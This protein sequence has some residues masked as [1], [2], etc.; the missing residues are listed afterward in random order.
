MTPYMV[1]IRICLIINDRVIV[2]RRTRD[3]DRCRSRVPRNA[4]AQ[5]RT[6]PTIDDV[7]LFRV[8]DQTHSD[9]GETARLTRVLVEPSD[10]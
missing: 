3:P 8:R 7:T 9:A 10:R 4:R 2:Y 1:P 5:K 6:C